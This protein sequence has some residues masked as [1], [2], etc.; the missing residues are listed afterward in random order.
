MLVIGLAVAEDATGQSD[1][2]EAHFKEGLR[3]GPWDPQC[4]I[5]YARYL[6]AHSRI[7]EAR[8]FLEHALKLSP[9]DLTA[10]QLLEETEKRN[11][12]E[13]AIKGDDLL[14]EGRI[15]EAMRRYEAVL[16][17]APDAAPTLNNFAWA[18]STAPDPSLRDGTRAL[19]MAQRADKLAGGKN[20]VFLRTMAAAYAESGRFKEAIATA[21][22]ARQLALAQQNSAL[23]KNLSQDLS[24]YEEGRALH[25]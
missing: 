19:A 1:L 8:G 20:P 7:D 14:R 11:V 2:A 24:F 22:R 4:Y 15:A 13:E 6:L 16:K 9:A 12:E 10:R 5:Y 23:A 18:L 25:R 17:A 3:R 21:E